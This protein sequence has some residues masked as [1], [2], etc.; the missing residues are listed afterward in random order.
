MNAP[1]PGESR[2][3]PGVKFGRKPELAPQQID[4]ARELIES[5]HDRQGIAD[6][7]R[8]LL[9][10]SGSCHFENCVNYCV[11]IEIAKTRYRTN[12][13]QIDHSVYDHTVVNI[14]ADYLA[15]ND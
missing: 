15:Y 7:F 11:L 3:A 4:R 2:N 6:L 1:A 10:S 13:R 5:E 12:P 9:R 8:A 14:D